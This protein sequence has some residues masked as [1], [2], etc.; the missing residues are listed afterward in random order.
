MDKKKNEENIDDLDDAELGSLE[1]RK[2][3]IKDKFFDAC[4][5]GD[6]NGVNKLIDN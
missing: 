4:K 1:D 5:K 2:K 6:L 3:K